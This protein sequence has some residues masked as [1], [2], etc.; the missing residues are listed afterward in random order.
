M[1]WYKNR[2]NY[3]LAVKIFVLFTFFL[4]FVYN[5]KISNAK[6]IGKRPWR[7]NKRK[8]GKN[9]V[10]L[11]I[12]LLYAKVIFFMWDLQS[13]LKL[14]GKVFNISSKVFGSFFHITRPMGWQG[15]VLDDLTPVILVKQ[16]NNLLSNS[17]PWPCRMRLGNLN[18][19]KYLLN[20]MCA[21]DLPNLFLV[22][23]ACTNFVKWCTSTNKYSYPPLHWSNC[24]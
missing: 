6:S 20:K 9:P 17:L 10:V 5:G 1:V 18:S 13:I 3:F 23:N 22:G 11:C 16:L 8:W 19:R 14:V 24:R 21:A 12:V 15:V 2:T 4:R 7:Q